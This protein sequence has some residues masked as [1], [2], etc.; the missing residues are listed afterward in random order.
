M[1]IGLYGDSFGYEKPIYGI[2]HPKLS[3]INPSWV[4]L[5]REHYSIDNFC[6]PASDLY[7]SYNN[8]VSN[9]KKFDLNIFIATSP[10]RLSINYNNTI[11]H[12][13]GL[14]S[15]ES[16][17]KTDS[18]IFRNKI[19]KASVDYFLYLQ[20]IQRDVVFS[21]LIKESIQK[22]DQNCIIIDAFGS[23]GLFNITNMENKSWK[24]SPSY[25]LLD[26]FLDLRYCHFT[27]ENNHILYNTICLCIKNK[28]NFEL[29]LKNFVTPSFDVRRKYLIKK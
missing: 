10:H 13:S 14:N 12:N 27:E 26:S 5:L 11:I 21:T 25:T 7:F 17:L 16:K 22:L 8:F 23:N 29:D 2:N 1:K 15:A 9:Y 24:I 6:C 18:D 19:H 4:T 20:D 28:L 3:D